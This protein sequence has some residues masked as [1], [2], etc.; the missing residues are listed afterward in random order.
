VLNAQILKNGALIDTEEHLPGID[1]I[2][3]AGIVI[4]CRLAAPK[5]AI[6]PVAGVFHI[7]VGRRDLDTLVKC[8]RN[9]RAEVCLNA[10]TL[11]RPHEDVPAVHVAVEGHTLLRDL[12]QLRQ[13]KNLESATVSQNRFFPGHEFVQAAQVADQ[14][15]TGTHV[16]MIGVGQ[17]DLTAD[18]LQ[19][20]CRER[21]LD[22]RLCAD[23]HKHRRL[24][25]TVRRCKRAA[26]R[27]AVFANQLKHSLLA[28]LFGLPTYSNR[29][30]HQVKRSRQI[31]VLRVS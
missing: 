25:R 5:P 11:F 19:I 21:A 4:E 12:P 2:I 6:C 14:L 17:L 18:C 10:H 30:L 26:A 23:I 16:Q 15:I 9:V 13:R 3:A 29:L 28:F 27:M 1:S 31:C 8:H 24:D 20:L 22:R 7:I